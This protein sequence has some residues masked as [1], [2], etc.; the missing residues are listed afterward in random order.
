MPKDREEKEPLET[1]IRFFEGLLFALPISAVLWLAIG[2]G[3]SAI[4]KMLG[5]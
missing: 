2:A 5:Y 3:I 1:G 4:Y